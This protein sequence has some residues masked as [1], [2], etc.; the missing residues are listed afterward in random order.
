[1][2]RDNANNRRRFQDDETKVPRILRHMLREMN[3]RQ[4]VLFI[5]TLTGIEGLLPDPYFI[6]GGVSVRLPK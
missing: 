2:T 3:S 4:F 1:M 6:G 5:E